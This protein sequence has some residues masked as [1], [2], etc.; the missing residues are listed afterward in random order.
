MLVMTVVMIGVTFWIERSRLGYYLEAIREDE[1]IAAAVGVNVFYYKV[2]IMAISGFFVAFAGTFYA[3]YF[4]FFDPA[5]LFSMG[6]MVQMQLGT[7]VGG[8]GTILGPIVGSTVYIVIE[9]L[10]RSLP[11]DSRQAVSLSKVV[12][13]IALMAIIFWLPGGL[14][15]FFNRQKK[16]IKP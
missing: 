10:L 11:F 1:D 2:L 4:M 12:Y 6:P 16:A 8:A 7:M 15:S 3:Q 9:Q 14:M 5:T 13:G